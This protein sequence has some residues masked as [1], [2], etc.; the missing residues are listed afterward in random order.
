MGDRHDCFQIVLHIEDRSAGFLDFAKQA[1]H[2]GR[3][4]FRE[5][6]ANLVT[7]QE[8]GASGESTGQLE[9]LLV[10]DRKRSA[11]CVSKVCDSYPLEDLSCIP[12]GA[13]RILAATEAEAHFHVFKHGKSPERPGHL[14]G[15]DDAGLDHGEGLR[16]GQ[17]AV[18][19]DDCSRSWL[20]GPGEDAQQRCLA[21]AVGAD[22][23][24]NPSR[25]EVEAHLVQRSQPGK[26]LGH[27]VNAK[28]GSQ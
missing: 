24:I 21:G 10:A 4:G 15:P 18:L 28:D 22:Q 26:V 12:G 14:V 23:A 9:T 16:P 6:A 5:P 1:K 17:V 13:R 19:K 3:L 11:R 8:A 7:E 20:D 27:A 2:R 25:L